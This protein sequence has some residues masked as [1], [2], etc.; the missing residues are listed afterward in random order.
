LA[1]NVR[2]LQNAIQFAFVKCS[3]KVIE[4]EDLP[5]NCARRPMCAVAG[6]GAQTR[7][8]S[9]A[10]GAC[11]HGRQQ[12]QSGQDHGVGRATLY[13]FLNDHPELA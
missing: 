10:E 4:I 3:G 11:P 12:S 6:A 8:G 5:L 9:G 7:P 1:G 13:R 2:E